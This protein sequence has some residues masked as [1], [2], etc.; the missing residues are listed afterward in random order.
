MC[1]ERR[2]FSQTCYHD[3]CAPGVR[4]ACYEMQTKLSLPLRPRLGKQA[5][6][7]SGDHSEAE[8]A[9]LAAFSLGSP[10]TSYFL[11][12]HEPRTGKLESVFSKH[13]LQCVSLGA[14][15]EWAFRE[16]LGRCAVGKMPFPPMPFFVPRFTAWGCL[17]NTPLLITLMSHGQRVLN[18]RFD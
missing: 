8:K 5:R 16:P 4:T 2:L 12:T 3:I 9:M 7:P 14:P 1:H 18:R 15:H 13:L 11:P 17:S 6:F 10:T